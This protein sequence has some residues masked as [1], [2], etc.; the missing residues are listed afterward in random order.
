MECGSCGTDHPSSEDCPRTDQPTKAT[1]WVGLQDDETSYTS[2]CGCVLTTDGT[3]I[4]RDGC[5]VALFVC[6]THEHAEEL[7]KAARAVATDATADALDIL[8]AIVARINVDDD[9][10]GRA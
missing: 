8:R 5:D 2:T 6:P 4:Y 1:Y 7:L 3:A 10:R 9:I